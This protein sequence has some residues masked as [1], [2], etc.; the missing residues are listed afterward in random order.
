MPLKV[1]KYHLELRQGWLYIDV[2]VPHEETETL[3]A[4]HIHM[5][6]KDPNDNRSRFALG[7]ALRMD[8]Q[9]KKARLEYERVAQT[10]DPDWSSAVEMTLAQI[11]GK[12]D[13]FPPIITKHFF[14]M[15]I[16]PDPA[17]T[18]RRLKLRITRRLKRQKFITSHAIDAD[19]IISDED[20]QNLYYLKCE[21][22]LLGTLKL[23]QLDFPWVYCHFQ[24][25]PTFEDVKTRFD[26]EMNVA[27]TDIKEWEAWYDENIRILDLHLIDAASNQDVNFSIL[28]I[29]G[30]I[31]WFRPSSRR[32]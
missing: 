25:T 16:I 17:R 6:E 21:G 5:L 4:E 3:I 31:A 19:L 28:H 13:H 1:G 14:H 24:P 15:Q 23:D 2:E 8:G 20:K 10:K 30:G 27:S 12:P 32:N 11:K 26:A 7:N 18:W 22:A 29:Q 9:I